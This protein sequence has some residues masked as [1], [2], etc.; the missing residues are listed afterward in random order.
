MAVKRYYSSTAID[1][2]LASSC[3]S[4]STSIVV[5]S[6]TGF[7]TSYPYTLAL[8]YDTSLEELVNVVGASGTTLTLGTTVGVAS[9]TGRGVDS[10]TAQNHAAGASVKHVISGRDM[11]ET[12][13]HYNASGYYTITVGS[14]TDT[15][16]MHGIDSGEGDVVGTAKSQTLT[17]KTISGASNILS[18]ILPN[19]VTGTAVTQADTGT[20]TSTM[21]AN[22]TII[23]ADINTSAAIA[24]SKISGLDTL[25]A[26]KAPATG[27]APSAVTGTAVTQADTGT[28]TNGMLAGSI[29]D[30]KLS[31]ITT[32]S[33]VNT[34][35]ITG[36]LAVANGG[37]GVTTSTGSGNNVLS[38]GATI[39]GASIGGGTMSGTAISSATFGGTISN[40]T[41]SS[42]TLADI[43]ATPSAVPTQVGAGGSSY[44]VPANVTN[45]LVA[46]TPT[47]TITL[48][49]ATAGRELRVL[50]V[51]SGA[52][53]SASSNVYSRTTGT[54][55][56]AICSGTRGSWALL[57]ADGTNWYI[58]AGA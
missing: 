23:D 39:T 33:K 22:G 14:N 27:I 28:V 15:F 57:V 49:T 3:T 8:G 42:S 11:R 40:A 29:A 55:G 20:V 4:S 5:S 56:T 36:T 50:N 7:P 53:S 10:T 38:S 35:A 16:K 24:T 18:N 52:V 45:A 21:I 31:Q 54:L 13:E 37:T 2:T 6:V 51:G 46:G 12:Q 41:I 17:N 44:T 43:L 1:T 19:A 58:M 48:P 32:A 30:T 9:T 26:G 47:A 25:L 34:S